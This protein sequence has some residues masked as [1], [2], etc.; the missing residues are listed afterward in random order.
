MDKRDIVNCASV[1]RNRHLMRALLQHAE[2]VSL[3]RNVPIRRVASFHKRYHT[4]NPHRGLGPSGQFFLAGEVSKTSFHSPDWPESLEDLQAR[5]GRFMQDY[6]EAGARVRT[7]SST[8]YHDQVRKVV[9]S[10]VGYADGVEPLGELYKL[11]F[12]TGQDHHATLIVSGRID[13]RTGRSRG[14][15]PYY[16][17]AGLPARPATRYM[18]LACTTM[19]RG[20]AAD[21]TPEVVEPSSNPLCPQ[22][23][24]AVRYRT[25]TS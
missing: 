5:G 18:R 19:R 20:N 13:S 25:S 2:R 8:I 6:G 10:N 3:S 24:D 4:G 16:H 9:H 12:I 7:I 17:P 15:P 14:L 11:L 1:A 23:L 22:Y 21:Q